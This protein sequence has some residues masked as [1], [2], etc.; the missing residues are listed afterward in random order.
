MN[1]AA[2]AGYL[3]RT[4]AKLEIDRLLAANAVKHKDE[5]IALSKAMYVMSPFTSLLVLETD[6]DY[7]KYKVDRGRKDHWATYQ[8]PAK[9]R[10]VYEPDGK[11]PVK[12]DRPKDA[13]PTCDEVMGTIVGW[14]VAYPGNGFRSL[15]QQGSSDWAIGIHLASPMGF[16]AEMGASRDFE[17]ITLH[18][19]V[20]YDIALLLDRA[21][22]GPQGPN[23]IEHIR[24]AA[25]A[26]TNTLF[27]KAKPIDMLTI[28]RLIARTI[29]TPP[30][31][32]SA[33]D[34][35]S[36]WIQRVMANGGG[37][38]AGGGGGFIA[39]NGFQQ[40]GSNVRFTKDSALEFPP[41]RGFKDL[42]GGIGGLPGTFVGSHAS[43]LGGGAPR[44]PVAIE[45]VPSLGIVISQASPNPF[46]QTFGD[47]LSMGKPTFGPPVVRQTLISESFVRGKEEFGMEIGLQAPLTFARWPELRIAERDLSR[48]KLFETDP[49]KPGYYSVPPVEFTGPLSNPGA[50]SGGFYTGSAFNYYN[51]NRRVS[52]PKK[53]GFLYERPPIEYDRRV[54]TDLVQYAPGLH[55]TTADILATLDAEADVEQPK[56]G[57]IDEAA[58]RLIERARAADWQTLTVAADGPLPG[59]SIH[60]NGVGQFT[61]TRILVSGL[62]EQV[63]CDGVTLWHL[64]PEIG[65]AAKR[66]FS[67]YQQNFVSS[68]NPAF[69]PVADELARG[70]DVK[71]VDANTIALV[72]VREG[73]APAEPKQQTSTGSTA[74]QE[75]RPPVSPRPVLRLVFAKDGRLSERQIVEMPSAKIV[76]RQIFHADG[77]IEWKDAADKSLDKWTRSLAP[78][79]SPNLVPNVAELVVM[80]MPTRTNHYWFNLAAKLGWKEADI[81]QQKLVTACHY[82][83]PG[84]AKNDAIIEQMAKIGGNRVGYCTLLSASDA[85][86]ER[87]IYKDYPKSVLASYLGDRQREL[88]TNGFEIAK[89][90]LGPKDGFLQRMTR[91]RNLWLTWHN[92]RVTPGDMPI[93]MAK[94]I[95]FLGDTPSPGFAYAVLDTMQRR[96]NK[97]PTDHMLEIAVKRFGPISDPLG[98]GY[99]FRYEHARSLSQAGKIA[100]SAKAFRELHADTLKLGVLPPIDSAFR[101]T[102]QMPIG[103]GPKFIS[104]TRTMLDDL[105]TKKRFGNAFQLSKQI[106]Q[107]GDEAL[108]DEIL[109]TILAKAPRS[110]TEFGNEHAALTLVSI[111][112]LAER[113][114]FAQADRLLAKVLEDKKLSR[115]AGLWRWRAEFA[116]NLGQSAV[117]LTCL[118][119]ALDLEY[120][121]LPELVNLESIRGDYRALLEQYQKI[122]EASAS[123]EK[124]TL[125]PNPS[126][127]GRG[128]KMSAF[129]AKVI[130]TADRWRLIDPDASEPSQLAG[131]I[132]HTLGERD[133]AWDYWTTPIDLHPAESRPWLDLAETMKAEGDLERADRAFSLA[134]EAEPTNPE[135]LWKQAQNL[136]RMSEPDR[137]RQLYRQIADGVWQERFAGI[138][139]QARGLA[140]E[141]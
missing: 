27:I 24:I 44:M 34:G 140:A 43:A 124:D 58:R 127:K 134:F 66:P 106:E 53:V 98:L 116:R 13:K 109:T 129:L 104:F 56:L 95:E 71:A 117:A 38:G 130:R 35:R 65:L 90:L 107:L 69:L 30:S 93:E 29:D 68:F 136:V 94:V 126:P 37:G 28:R 33:F 31:T 110:Q 81:E 21:F 2:G 96:A 55:N 119:A 87:D 23:R 19:T 97:P 86:L 17:A 3:P 78:T 54:F 50:E 99:V 137:A 51:T 135:I 40:F 36:A 108:A 10:L 48:L 20:A 128:E 46:V 6:A 15:I 111:H 59:Y 18:N 74:R 101:E 133:L 139:T 63:I 42:D 49:S 72:P 61:Y 32:W 132:F 84:D 52:D 83:N 60:F 114:N 112:F 122:A 120:H 5:I 77:A 113:K 8:C 70:H 76:L 47:P 45:P 25:D 16:R 105:L 75:P 92:Q 64:Y 7:E 125:T 115:H 1:A 12:V 39:G 131:K 100:E 123:L 118:E 121:E 4:W 102:L 88:K 11:P 82:P 89:E 41:Q 73:E 57:R 141:R 26:R 22:N 80:S 62:R 9:I 138:V 91:F 14:H 103:E 79:K 85:R 67:R